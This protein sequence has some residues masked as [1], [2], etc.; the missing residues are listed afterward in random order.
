MNLFDGQFKPRP[1]INLAGSSTTKSREALIAQAI[2]ERRKREADRQQQMSATRIQACFRSYALRK[3]L[4]DEYRLKFTQLFSVDAKDTS[5]LISY[6]VLFYE[7]RNGQDQERLQAFSQHILKHK[8]NIVHTVLLRDSSTR[9]SLCRLLAIH[10]RLL[11]SP[12]PPAHKPRQQQAHSPVAHSLSLR[13]IDYLTDPDSY[14]ALGYP[15]TDFEPELA[16]ILKFLIS[17]GEFPRLFLFEIAD[18]DSFYPFSTQ[19]SS[20]A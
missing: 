17:H 4:R 2:A 18:L 9:Y 8:E 6:F 5:T 16:L 13:L 1:S 14:S 3:R 20:A 19:A 10:L 11:H 15:A 12:A 7:P